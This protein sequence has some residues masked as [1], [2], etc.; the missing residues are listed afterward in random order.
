MNLST[1]ANSICDDH[2]DIV[3]NV[4]DAGLTLTQLCYSISVNKSANAPTEEID[5]P[6]S[7]ICD[8]H[9]IYFTEF[10][11]TDL[12]PLPQL[13]NSRN[14]VVVDNFLDRVSDSRKC[15]AVSRLRS[16]INLKIPFGSRNVGSDGSCGSAYGESTLKGCYQYH[17]DILKLQFDAAALQGLFKITCTF[18]FL[19]HYSICPC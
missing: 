6:A 16:I 2:V 8:N 9:D 17:G 11:Y 10:S 12:M 13:G 5:S 1:N 7:N 4:P 15:A 3:A 14:S 19:S 18:K